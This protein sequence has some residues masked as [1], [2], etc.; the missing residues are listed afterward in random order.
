MRTA[1]LSAIAL[2]PLLILCTSCPKPAAPAAAYPP[3]TTA[4]LTAPRCQGGGELRLLAPSG[5][6]AVEAQFCACRSLE[7]GEGQGEESIPAGQ[8]RFELR[9]QRT[10]SAIWVEVEGRGVYYKPPERLETVC[11]YVD[12]PPGEHRVT[13]HSEGR[14]A[15]VGLQTGLQIFEH[16]VKDGPH[17]YR[18]VDLICGSQANRCTKEA[19]EQWLTFQRGLPRGVL[20]PCGSTM[21]RGVT[22]GGNRAQRQDIEYADLTVRFRMKI[23][24]FETYRTPGSPECRAPVKNRPE[25]AE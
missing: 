3:T 11:F 22:V 13:V 25:R 9:L 7:S 21:I 10:T 19:V 16:G 8:K 15:D 5:R 14:D 4:T 24:A 23:Y 18:S 2:A 17:W 6:S 20:D 12:L 1:I